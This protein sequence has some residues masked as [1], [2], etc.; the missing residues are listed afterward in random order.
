MMTE[1]INMTEAMQYLVTQTIVAV[2]MLNYCT[3]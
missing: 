3:W 1:Y 2:A